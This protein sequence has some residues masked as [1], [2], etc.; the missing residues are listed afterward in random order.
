MF[1][2]YRGW[3]KVQFTFKADEGWGQYRQG[4][5]SRHHDIYSGSIDLHRMSH[6]RKPIIH[7]WKLRRQRWMPPKRMHGTHILTEMTGRHQRKLSVGTWKVWHYIK[8]N[9]YNCHNMGHIY[10]N[11]SEAGHTG[12]CYHQ[13]IHSFA[14]NQIQHNDPTNKNWIILDT[15]YSSSV[16]KMHLWPKMSA[17]VNYMRN[18]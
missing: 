18:W 1:P 16:L 13:V 12:T 5:I 9:F 14:R 17:S 8:Y 11:C 7:S 15:C 3:K 6:P 4:L 2:A 10:Y